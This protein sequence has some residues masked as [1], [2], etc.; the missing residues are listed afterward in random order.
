MPK[1]ILNN[2]HR[3]PL[4]FV[5]AIF[6]VGCGTPAA[7]GMPLAAAPATATAT[8]SP[9]PA[10]VT[11]PP[12]ATATPT[13]FQPIPP[14]AVYLPTE[15]PLPTATPLP[16]KPTSPPPKVRSQR[17]SLNQPDNQINI[18]L[19]G[20]DQRPWDVAFR[21]DTII[22][23]TL[24]PDLGTVNLTSFPRDL[25]VYIPGWMKVFSRSWKKS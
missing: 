23:A 7:V 4:L 20:S 16:P 2:L 21:T 18:L 24:N 3:I 6:L 15:T 8:A 13:P 22:L 9:S 14:T 1:M 10:Y 11:A 17:G 25:Y 19:L 12:D 5:L